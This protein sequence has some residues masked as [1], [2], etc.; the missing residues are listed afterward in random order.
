MVPLPHSLL[1]ER[2]DYYRKYKPYKYLFDGA[3]STPSDPEKYSQSSI[4][5]V[6]RRAV[7]HAVI[8]RRVRTHNLRHS[9]ATHMLESGVDIWYIQEL[10]GHARTKTT[11]IYYHVSVKKLLW[12]RDQKNAEYY[13]NW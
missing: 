11:E 12:Q 2:R 8:G 13:T 1:I 5:Q 4:H 10:L 6:L 3:G 7:K 9:Y